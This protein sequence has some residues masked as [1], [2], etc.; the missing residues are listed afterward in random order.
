VI[1]IDL[2]SGIEVSEAAESADQGR[3]H[4]AEHGKHRTKGKLIH[5][6]SCVDRKANLVG[7]FIRDIAC[8]KCSR[9]REEEEAAETQERHGPESAFEVFFYQFKK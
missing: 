7:A 3:E 5:Q 4:H 9:H 8:E 2:A 1:E 6:F